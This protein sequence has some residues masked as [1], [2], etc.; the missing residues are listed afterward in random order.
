MSG[1]LNGLVPEFPFPGE[2]G[3]SFGETVLISC[4][5][6]PGVAGTLSVDWHPQN[7]L[8]LTPCAG[9]RFCCRN[10]QNAFAICP[11][12]ILFRG[13]VR[14]FP[15]GNLGCVAI[16]VSGTTATCRRLTPTAPATWLRCESS[17][18]GL[19]QTQTLP[20]AVADLFRLQNLWECASVAL[21]RSPAWS[22]A[23]AGLHASKLANLA[24]YAALFS[25]DEVKLQ[26]V[27]NLP[28]LSDLGGLRLR[29]S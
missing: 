28:E 3:I 8:W 16:T 12:N 27:L 15:F 20:S 9:L 21:C 29:I 19:R 1:L 17:E 24:A 7:P 23:C 14:G 5:L 4:R 22:A 25:Q 13:A 18:S 10:Q 2:P 6:R 11:N 26:P